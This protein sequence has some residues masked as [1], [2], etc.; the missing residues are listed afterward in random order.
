MDDL[1]RKAEDACQRQVL[2]EKIRVAGM[3][4]SPLEILRDPRGVG[5]F[6]W[7]KVRPRVNKGSDVVAGIALF[8]GFG[9]ALIWDGREMRDWSGTIQRQ[10]LAGKAFLS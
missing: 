6:R 2:G 8:L 10:Q 7:R 1:I 3:G 4:R 9:V 5:G